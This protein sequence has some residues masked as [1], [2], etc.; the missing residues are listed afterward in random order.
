MSTRERVQAVEKRVD[1]A[2]TEVEFIQDVIGYLVLQ[3]DCAIL[4]E[5]HGVDVWIEEMKG[6]TKLLHVTGTGLQITAF[7]D[8]LCSRMR[9]VSVKWITIPYKG[10]FRKWRFNK[11]I[12]K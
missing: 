8:E 1:R 12:A 6:K 10:V 4:A 3:E 11:R 5:R 9:N 7:S 2:E